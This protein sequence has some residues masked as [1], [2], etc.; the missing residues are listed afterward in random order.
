MV[1]TSLQFSLASF[2]V[3]QTMGTCSKQSGV[4]SIHTFC[5]EVLISLFFNTMWLKRRLAMRPKKILP[6]T[7]RSAMERKS[8][9][10]DSLGW[11]VL[12]IYISLQA[13][14]LIG[15]SLAL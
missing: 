4:F 13:L 3:D 7:L 1:D 8:G 9:I 14:Q 15:T 12:G 10:W 5:I 6:S 2:R 11:S